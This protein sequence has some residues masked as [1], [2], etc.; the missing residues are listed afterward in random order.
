MNREQVMK[1]SDDELRIRIAML[2]GATRTDRRS[3]CLRQYRPEDDEGH[4]EGWQP[5]K[6]YPYDI[7]AAWELWSLI[8][9]GGMPLGALHLIRVGESGARVA[10]GYG[11]AIGVIGGKTEEEWEYSP[12]IVE[13]PR[14]DE[15]DSI[16][17][18]RAIS[19]AFVL[20]REVDD[21]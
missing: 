16:T 11:L 6:D 5:I 15:V 3:G 17:A 2:Q 20:S 12:L 9:I 1:M 14:D 7:A 19:R 4:G 13:E 10:I 21:A 18:A 8:P